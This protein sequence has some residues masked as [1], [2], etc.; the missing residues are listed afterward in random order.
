MVKGCIVARVLPLRCLLYFT[1]QKYQFLSILLLFAL[2]SYKPE[3]FHPKFSQTTILHADQFRR[4]VNITF[5]RNTC[6][7]IVM[8]VYMYIPEYIYIFIYM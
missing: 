3:V 1:T 2:V 5:N 4:V 8:L 6:T 7:H